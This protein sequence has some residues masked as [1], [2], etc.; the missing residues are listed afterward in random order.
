VITI[1]RT[2]EEEIRETEREVWDSYIKSIVRR[3]TPPN[4]PMRAMAVAG[5]TR[6][7]PASA[8]VRGRSSAND[9]KPNDVAREKG[10]ANHTK[11]PSKYPLCVDDGLA[12]M[13]LTQ[14]PWSSKEKVRE[15]NFF[16]GAWKLSPNSLGNEKKWRKGNQKKRLPSSCRIQGKT[17]IINKHSS[18]VSNNVDDSKN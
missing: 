11:P 18:K 8:V 5:G 3:R 15:L 14:Y 2:Q 6:P 13:A 10:T 4:F 1:Y 16:S 7:R 9:P 17:H 12:A